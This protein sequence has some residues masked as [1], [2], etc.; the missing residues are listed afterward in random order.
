MCLITCRLSFDGS[1]KNGYYT[2]III[3]PYNFVQYVTDAVIF[4]SIV[5]SA[6]IF[7]FSIYTEE[8]QT[9]SGIKNCTR[10]VQ[11]YSHFGVNTAF[12]NKFT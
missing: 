5:A 6:Y 12:T 7:T 2:Y 8:K 1:Q 11:V 4:T 3:G 9:H 10:H